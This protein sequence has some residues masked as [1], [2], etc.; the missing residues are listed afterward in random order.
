[1]AAK[2]RL[3]MP[4]AKTTDGYINAISNTVFVGSGRKLEG[5]VRI[6]SPVSSLK[7]A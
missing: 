1:M 6:T 4:L 7:T 3:M 5:L 2:E